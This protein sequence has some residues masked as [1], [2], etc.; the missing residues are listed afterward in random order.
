MTSFDELKLNKIR[1]QLPEVN[2][3]SGNKR[4]SLHALR[5]ERERGNN[6]SSVKIGSEISSKEPLIRPYSHH[7]RWGKSPSPLSYRTQAP[8]PDTHSGSRLTTRNLVH[9]RKSTGS[10]KR[11]HFKHQHSGD[12]YSRTP[13]P[14]STLDEFEGKSRDVV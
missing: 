4:S 11:V 9:H 10:A 8:R 2:F 6:H 12:L 5:S 1:V 14:C 13:S 7:V 3:H